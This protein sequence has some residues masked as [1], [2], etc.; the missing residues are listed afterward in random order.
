[1]IESSNKEKGDHA[2]KNAILLRDRLETNAMISQEEGALGNL[3]HLPLIP[4]K[5][6]TVMIEGPAG[7]ITVG[8]GEETS[9]LTGGSQSSIRTVSSKLT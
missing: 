9:R 4:P 6:L 1:L 7:L 8:R 2:Q 5:D 3:D